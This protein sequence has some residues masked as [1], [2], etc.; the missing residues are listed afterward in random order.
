MK[1][2]MKMMSL[3]STR[4]REKY[5]IDTKMSNESKTMKANVKNAEVQTDKLVLAGND[6]AKEL[7][8]FAK[9]IKNMEDSAN[10]DEVNKQ[11]KELNY[12]LEQLELMFS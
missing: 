9:K 6:V 12:R 7:T 2:M 8:K 1:K 3:L 10:L 11:L 4:L 5:T